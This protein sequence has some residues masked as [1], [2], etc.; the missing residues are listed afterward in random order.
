MFLLL[1]KNNCL[2]GFWHLDMLKM[3]KNRSANTEGLYFYILKRGDFITVIMSTIYNLQQ[4]VFP[5][6]LYTQAL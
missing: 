3:S 2:P 1:D 6:S 5:V 4:K